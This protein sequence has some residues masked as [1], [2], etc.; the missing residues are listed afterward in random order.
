MLICDFNESCAD[1][2]KHVQAVLV[3]Q[4]SK[5]VSQTPF[6]KNKG[7]LV[8]CAFHPSKPFLFLASQHQV[9]LF[10]CVRLRFQHIYL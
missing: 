9:P 3:H 4:L 5:R 1:H 10:N 7:R 8:D 6:R 2:V